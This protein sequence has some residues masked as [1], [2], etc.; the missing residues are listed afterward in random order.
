MV[1]E[2][3]DHARGRRA[4]TAHP[5]NRFA[6]YEVSRARRFRALVALTWAGLLVSLIAALSGL[7]LQ[8]SL[9]QAKLPFLLGMHLSPDG[10]I[11]GAPLTIL[12]TLISI[13]CCIVVA[14]LVAWGR[15]SSNAFAFAVASFYG[16][17][18]RGT[19]LMLQVLLIYLALPQVGVIMGPVTSGVIALSLNYGAYL[20][21]TIRGGVLAVPRGQREAALALGLPPH[22]IAWHVVAPQALRI[23]IPPAGSLFVS[24]LKDSSLV[25]LM[26]VWELNFLAQS[27]GRSTYR[28]MEMLV[29]AAAIYW[30]MSILCELL[31]T[32][33]EKRYGRGFELR[34]PL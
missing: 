32:R 25:S 27:Y 9:I 6:A 30:V 3:G 24:M 2:S 20:A 31:Q 33:L 8:F 19:P 21:E 22:V 16:S 11:Q 18:F 5:A 1:S 12:I 34:P 15:M 4:A 17:C 7:G 26:G 28:Y 13:V 10:F 29:T 23:I 14:V